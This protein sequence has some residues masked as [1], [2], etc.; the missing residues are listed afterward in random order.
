VFRSNRNGGGIYEVPAFG[1][2]SRLLARDGLNPRFSPDGS[3]VAYWV[4]ARLAQAIPGA[5]AVW[6]VP[7]SGGQPEKVGSNFTSAMYPIWSP[8]STRILFIGYTSPEAYQSD[9]LDWWIVSVNGGRTV[10]TGAHRAFLRAGLQYT[11][12]NTPIPA[13]P[14]PGCWADDGALIFSFDIGDVQNLWKISLSS[15]SGEVSGAQTHDNG[16]R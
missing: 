6:V 5:G 4:G 10:R 2:E 12:A 16:L 11:Y 1:G 14:I 8:D 3:R 15:Q 13:V 9:S 7:A